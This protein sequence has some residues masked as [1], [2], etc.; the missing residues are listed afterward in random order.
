MNGHRDREGKFRLE[1]LFLETNKSD[2]VELYTLEPFKK[3]GLPSLHVLY[4]ETINEYDFA[5]KAFNNSFEQFKKLC[6]QDWFMVGTDDFIGFNAWKEEKRL[7]LDAD[8]RYSLEAAK[9]EGN[10]TAIKEL[11]AMNNKIEER[12]RGRP[13]DAELEKKLSRDER[14][15]EKVRKMKER[16]KMASNG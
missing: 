11:N 1:S 6:L 5:M 15:I 4:M 16:L 7:K 12:G 8:L 2:L 10:I 14:Y 3:N 13:S 9:A